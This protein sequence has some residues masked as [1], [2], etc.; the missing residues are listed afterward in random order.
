MTIDMFK[1]NKNL[2]AFLTDKGLTLKGREKTKFFKWQE[3][4]KWIEKN[5]IGL[6]GICLKFWSNKVY[7][8]DFKYNDNYQAFFEAAFDK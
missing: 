1:I 2:F 6:N 5:T 4:S 7:M 8:K 3:D